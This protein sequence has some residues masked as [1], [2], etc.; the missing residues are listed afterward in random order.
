[1]DLCGSESGK[2]PLIC[3]DDVGPYALWLFDNLSESAGMDLMV[4]TDEICFADIAAVFTKVTGKKGVH[5]YIPIEDWL[6]AAEPYPNAP[7]NFVA[8]PNAHRDEASMTW[9]ENFTAW[10]RYWGEGVC[11][12]RDI[13]LLDRIHPTRVK[14]LEDWMRKYQYDGQGRNVLKGVEDLKKAAMLMMGQG[15]GPN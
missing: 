5:Q 4:T 12:K 9:R 2:L 6:N 11:Q 10:W 3:L 15:K 8:G 14:N 1:M 13:Q 7:A